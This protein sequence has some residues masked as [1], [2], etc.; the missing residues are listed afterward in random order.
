MSTLDKR[1]LFSRR[2]DAVETLSA[3]RMPH[4]PIETLRHPVHRRGWLVRRLLLL[5]DVAGLMLAFGVAEVW[6]SGGHRF[7]TID[8][9]NEL[10]IFLATLPVW[11]VVAKLYGLYS[12]DEERTDHSTADDVIGVFHMVT[13]GSWS[14]FIGA[15]I[16]GFAH[17]DIP[18]LGLF[19]VLAIAFVTT[20]RAIGRT[21]SRRQ[22]AYIQNTLIVGAGNV[23]QLVAE[24]ITRH[25]EY[26]LNI[27]AFVD[28]NPLELRPSLAHI[29]VHESF[30]DLKDLVRLL[31]VERVIIAFSGEP[32]EET[33]DTI[34]ALTDLDIQIDVVPRLFEIVGAGFTT[35]TVEGL[36][37]LGMPPVRLSRSSYLLKRTLD[38]AVAGTTL[39]LL[40]PLFALITLAIKLDS[41]GPVFF[42]QKRMGAGDVIFQIFKF[43]TMV[44]DADERKQEFAHLNRHAHNQGARMFK[45][46]SDPRV[47]RAGRVLRRYFLD[48]LPQL[49]NV[50]KGDMSLVGPRPLILDEDEFVVDWARRRLDLRPGMTGL[51]QV[52]GRSHIPFEEMVALD[53]Q[54]V[55]KWSLWGDVRLLLRTIPLLANGHGGSY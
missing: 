53:Y 49:I 34:R 22:L 24:K 16:T 45:I 38:L 51:W 9:P 23:G 29:A 6:F 2:D 31:D 43:R 39:V 46:A 1:G 54:Y 48:E 19:W 44:R 20:G 12:H 35:H 11:I 25:P 7:D 37:L 13:V 17:P 50:V 47:T 18:K 41:P 40:A 52:H 27:V 10:I 4:E 42:R 8:G 30:G 28:A 5:G 21:V 36:P 26:G 55:T 3:L 33:L 14:F 32:H 15:Y